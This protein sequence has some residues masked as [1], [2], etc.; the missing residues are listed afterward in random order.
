VFARTALI[1]VA[2]GLFLG[3]TQ[4]AAARPVL[5][6]AGDSGRPSVSGGP[7]G[8]NVL[9]GSI[10]QTDQTWVC[11]GPVDL[12]SVSV[13]MTSAFTSRQGGDAVHLEPGCTGRI[14]RLDVA[15]SV[16]DG[17]KVAEGVHDL[18]VDAGS[19]RCAGTVADVH[20]DGMQVMGGARIT[21]R[22]L[23]IDCGRAQDTLINSNLFIK[24]SG[25]SVNP[26]T[27]VICVDCSLGGSAAHTASIQESVR[28]GL[29]DSTLC[30]AKYAKLTLSIGP[31]AVDPVDVGNAIDAC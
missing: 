13:T 9:T 1:A 17:V 29:V 8:A 22:G 20:Q 25:R 23:R 2:V 24:R 3:L 7:S 15:T 30:S 5:E 10:A 28:S 12:D 19:I 26:P 11:R 31:N 18:A 6:W 16:A 14:G 27:D 21:L 4:L